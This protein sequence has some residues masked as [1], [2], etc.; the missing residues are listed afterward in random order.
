MFNKRR[1]NLQKLRCGQKIPSSQV[2]WVSEHQEEIKMADKVSNELIDHPAKRG[3]S[4][5]RHPGNTVSC[6]KLEPRAW[7][8]VV[9]TVVHYRPRESATALQWALL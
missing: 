8:R 5:Q 9:F 4:V 6:S 2:H 1:E 7:E 3:K